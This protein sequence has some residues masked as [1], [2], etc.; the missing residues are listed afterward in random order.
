VKELVAMER[1]RQSRSMVRP[2][3]QQ[4]GMALVHVFLMDIHATVQPSVAAN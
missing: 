2:R 3:L 4:G 1:I